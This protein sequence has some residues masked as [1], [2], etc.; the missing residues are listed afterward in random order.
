M[1]LTLDEILQYQERLQGEIVE[2]ECL[3]AS[4][5]VLQKYAADGQNP[6]FFDLRSAL[7]SST[8][9]L[10]A[11]A[12][13]LP[14]A[15]NPPPPAQPKPYVKPYIHP[16]LEVAARDLHGRNSRVVT[17]A[18]RRMTADYSLRDIHD[19]LEREGCPLRSSEISVVLTRLKGRGEIEEIKPGAGP[20]GAVFRKPDTATS[21]EIETPGPTEQTRSASDAAVTQ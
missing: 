19:L 8:L 9:F 13:Q 11:S 16:E 20:K 18:I 7:P 17:W 3:L 10:G 5:R 21:Q 15:P 4:L 6:K 2:R 1:P 12:E 14:A